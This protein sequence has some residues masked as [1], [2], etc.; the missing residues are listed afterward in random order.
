MEEF[1]DLKIDDVFVFRASTVYFDYDVDK[2]YTIREIT[3]AQTQEEL[4]DMLYDTKYI[5]KCFKRTYDDF[6]TNNVDSGW[7]KK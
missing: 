2:E 7:Y 1:K 5:N 6:M 4:D 3:G